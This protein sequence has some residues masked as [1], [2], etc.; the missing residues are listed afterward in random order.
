VNDVKD[1][2]YL[3]EERRRVLRTEYEFSPTAD[4]PV[5]RMFGE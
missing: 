1:N 2:Y 3:P 5:A 4:E